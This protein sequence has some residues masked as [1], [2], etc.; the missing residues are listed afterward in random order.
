M[1]DYQVFNSECSQTNTCPLARHQIGRGMRL[2]PATG[3]QDCRII[4][5][6]EAI[7]RV[8]GV[9]SSPTLF[10]LDPDLLVVEGLFFS[11]SMPFDQD[12]N[13]STT[14]HF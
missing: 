13:Q 14:C 8:G 11:L 5:F 7:D 3:K 12:P 4:D 1:V 2:S 10:G 6:V 9:I